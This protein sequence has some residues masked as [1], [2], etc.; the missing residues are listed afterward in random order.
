[1]KAANIQ[2]SIILPPLKGDYPELKEQSH[3]SKD[4]ESRLF[5][6]EDKYSRI[7]E[8]VVTNTKHI[9]EVKKYIDNY[10]DEKCK[11]LMV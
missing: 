9:E 6:I 10:I 8:S 11:K 3:H 1:M 4:F 2:Q 7:V 5:L